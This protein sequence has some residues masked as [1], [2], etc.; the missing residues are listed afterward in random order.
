[1]VDYAVIAQAL[2]GTED[3]SGSRPFVGLTVT[4]H[5]MENKNKA[6]GIKGTFSVPTVTR[7]TLSPACDPLLLATLSLL[8]LNK[9]PLHTRLTCTQA[10]N[11]IR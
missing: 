3:Y 11:T 10:L 7:D 8:L 6:S 1:M 5:M 9:D 2:T 4:S